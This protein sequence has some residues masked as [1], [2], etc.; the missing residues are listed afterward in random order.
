M[1]W[2]EDFYAHAVLETRGSMEDWAA[3]R[4]DAFLVLKAEMRKEEQRSNG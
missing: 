1:A 4:V 2:L 3:R